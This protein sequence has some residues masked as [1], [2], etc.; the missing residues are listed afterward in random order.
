MVHSFD[1]YDWNLTS[2]HTCCCSQVFLNPIPIQKVKD[3][4]HFYVNVCL[5][6]III[7]IKTESDILRERDLNKN[8]ILR[9]RERERDTSVK[10]MKMS[11]ESKCCL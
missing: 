8:K 10:E 4:L 11:T 9:E 2:S 1:M 7:I 3:I 5:F 6:V